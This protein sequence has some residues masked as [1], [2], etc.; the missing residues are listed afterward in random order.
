MDNVW[1][2]AGFNSIGI[3]SA[4]GA[5][6]ALAQWITDGKKPFDLG[7]VDISRMQPFQGNKKYLFERSKETL[8][9]LYADHY[10]Y[11]QK[12]SARGIRRSPFHSQ[13]LEKGA[14]MGELAGWERA[15]WYAE[16]GLL[17]IS[18]PC[19]VMCPHE[20]NFENCDIGLIGVPHSAGLHAFCINSACLSGKPKCF[21]LSGKIT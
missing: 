9:L 7:D 5:G 18:Y 8:G 1:I 16:S 10:P 11:R 2:A 21:N 19:Y 15:N 6:M 4:G 14:V 13:L 20:T 17:V 12:A 3:Q